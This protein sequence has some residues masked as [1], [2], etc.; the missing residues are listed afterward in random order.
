MRVAS[1]PRSAEVKPSV[2]E[3]CINSFPPFKIET[4]G[5]T[6]GLLCLM[7]LMSLGVFDREV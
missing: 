5:S 4:V 2:L 6:K 7:C 1:V 3:I